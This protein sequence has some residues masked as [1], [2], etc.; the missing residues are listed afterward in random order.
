MTA[1]RLRIIRPRTPAP[2]PEPVDDEPVPETL[3][4]SQPLPKKLLDAYA[5]LARRMDP[6]VPIACSPFPRAF[7]VAQTLADATG[8]HYRVAKLDGRGW[9]VAHEDW[10]GWT[11]P[12]A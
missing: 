3:P 2:E 6:M 8:E 7:C 11:D 1:P 4:A 10:D 12:D 9:V 5:N